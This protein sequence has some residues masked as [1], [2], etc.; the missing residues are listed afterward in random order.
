MKTILFTNA[1]DEYSILE[2]TIHHINLG[3]TTIYIYDHKS[4]NL[5]SEILDGLKNV[6]INRIDIDDI[7]KIQ[8]IKNAVQYSKENDY[9]W[10]LYLD[11]DE[12]LALPLYKNIDHFIDNYK[13]FDQI[14]INWVYFGSNFL[15]NRPS[16][17][18]LESYIRSTGCLDKHIKCF[19]RPKN[20]INI[21]NPHY[22]II[23]D[24]NRS[25]GIFYNKQDPNE[26]AHCPINNDIPLEITH[27]YIAHYIYQAYDVF[28]SRKIDKKR[29][30]NNK[31]F[32]VS[33]FDENMV[34]SHYN[35][36]ITTNIRDL[37]NDINKI[38]IDK[39]QKKN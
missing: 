1:R 6:I 35:N 32:E 21:V 20:I 13:E 3:F 8:L 37:Y 26:L 38:E 29:D 15:T 36:I 34:H 18:I 5:I 16:D 30:D 4:I 27:A 22:Y 7:S 33:H 17:T 9:D 24:Q 31:S 19:V 28:I 25:V 2:W 10:M 11:A 12:F 14:C 23:D 39:F